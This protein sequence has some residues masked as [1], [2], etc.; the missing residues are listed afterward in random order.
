MKEQIIQ[1]ALEATGCSRE[2]VFSSQKWEPL[3]LARYLIAW[4]L[5]GTMQENDIAD[6][7]GRD[8]STLIFGRNLIK[9]IL[10]QPRHKFRHI[11]ERFIILAPI[12][13]KGKAKGWVLE[14]TS[15]ELSAFYASGLLAIYRNGV[16]IRKLTMDGLKVGD[17]ET[18][19][20]SVE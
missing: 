15:G 11:V 13:V 6:I 8:R 2:D 5:W 1:A 10:N 3:P 9:E 16:Q 19:L 14:F 7:I 12:G 4:G 17:V 18:I 20:K